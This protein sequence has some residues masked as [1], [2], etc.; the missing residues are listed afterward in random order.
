MIKC[1][2][3]IPERDGADPFLGDSGVAAAF[4]ASLPGLTRY[5][6]SRRSSAQLDGMPTAGYGGAVE[7]WFDTPASA[8]NLVDNLDGLSATLTT[9][10]R[11]ALPVVLVTT[12]HVISGA[13]PDPD[14]PGLKAV[15]LFGRRR[16]MSVAD[17]QSYWLHKHGP[18][19]P[20][21]PELERYVQCHVLPECYEGERP[22]YDGVTELHWRDFD[23][24]RRSMAS[25]EMTVE[26]ASDAPN[27]ADGES[28]VVFLAEEERIL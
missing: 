5:V 13:E 16:G 7:C 24:A 17:F 21:T 4:A 23:A 22:A 20:K 18:I 27:F 19:V 6:Q 11:G 26:Q 1:Y 2:V 3:L 28:L 12:E 10:A 9:A 15:F 25:E 14:D 8:N